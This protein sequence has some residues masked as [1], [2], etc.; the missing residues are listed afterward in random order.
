MNSTHGARVTGYVTTITYDNVNYVGTY[1]VQNYEVQNM[2]TII[3]MWPTGPSASSSAG[4]GL[5]AGRY[6][7]TMQ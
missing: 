2:K 5:G 1:E 3:W 7:S 6:H 4:G